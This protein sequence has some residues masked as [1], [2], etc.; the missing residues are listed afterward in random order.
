ME[1]VLPHIILILETLNTIEIIVI[2][3]FIPI[4]QA[5]L[6]VLNLPP[7]FLTTLSPKP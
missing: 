6:Y 5:L 2:S 4:S 1:I 3:L 7:L